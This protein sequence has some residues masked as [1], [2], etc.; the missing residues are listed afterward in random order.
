MRPTYSHPDHNQKD[1]IAALKQIG[2]TVADLSGAGGGCPDL[3]IGYQGLSL[4]LEV[5]NTEGRNRV[6]PKQVKFHAEWRGGP[7][8]VVRSPQEAIDVCAGEAE[9]AERQSQPSNVTTVCPLCKKPAIL[10]DGVYLLRNRELPKPL[11]G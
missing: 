5:K 11:H 6:D 3:L 8:H 10:A 4:L 9:K 2:A 1:I 7:I